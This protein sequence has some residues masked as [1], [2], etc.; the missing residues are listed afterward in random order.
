MPA[1]DFSLTNKS[2]YKNRGD[3][4]IRVAR[5]GFDAE[6]CAQNQ[7]LFNSNWPILQI[8]KV[9]DLNKN[10]NYSYMYWD[11]ENEQWVENPDITGLTV[12][13]TVSLSNVSISKN[14]LVYTAVAEGLFDSDYNL[15][16]WRF[17]YKKYNHILGY[18]PFF[19]KSEE[20]SNI[21]DKVI[22]TSV[23][24]AKDIDYPYTDGPLPLL[25]TSKDYGI[26]SSSIFGSKVPGLSSNMFSKLVQCVKTTE[27]SRWKISE[28]KKLCWSPFKNAG[29]FKE[30]EINKYEAFAFSAYKCPFLEAGIAGIFIDFPTNSMNTDPFSNSLYFTR[31]AVVSMLPITDSSSLYGSAAAYCNV[32]QTNDMYNDASMVILRSPMVSPEYEEVII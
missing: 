12:S 29:E 1:L 7:L 32:G 30:G 26:S 13:Y 28:E 9:V 3:Y 5:P 14:S 21:G 11:L 19:F 6:N 23:D 17:K 25:S 22:L 27:T 15:K 10:P 2:N 24:I 20:V 16:Y 18:V 8:T 31:N 4:G